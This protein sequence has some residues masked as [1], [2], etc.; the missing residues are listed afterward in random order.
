L[1]LLLLLLVRGGFVAAATTTRA[2]R[3]CCCCYYYSHEALLCS[4][5]RARRSY[6]SSPVV[7]WNGGSR[8]R[9]V[10]SDFRCFHFTAKVFA[11]VCSEKQGY[12]GTKIEI[13]VRKRLSERKIQEYGGFLQEYAT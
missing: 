10:R 4:R 11:P 8:Q 13:P 6:V 9:V 3:L 1:L 7:H 5:A 2:R 12:G